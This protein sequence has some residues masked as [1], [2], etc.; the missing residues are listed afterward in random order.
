MPRSSKT[1]AKGPDVPARPQRAA[2][3]AGVAAATAPAKDTP[4]EAKANRLDKQKKKELKSAVVPAKSL[5]ELKRRASSSASSSPA[6]KTAHTSAHAAAALPKASRGISADDSSNESSESEATPEEYELGDLD[7]SADEEGSELEELDTHKP[8]ALPTTKQSRVKKDVKLVAE[9][10]C[11]GSRPAP[12]PTL[13][14]PPPKRV[15]ATERMTGSEIRLRDSLLPWM[16]R[17]MVS[18]P[19]SER[20]D[21]TDFI[22]TFW[23]S[24]LHIAKMVDILRLKSQDI[25]E[26]DITD[27]VLDQARRLSLSPSSLLLTLSSSYCSSPARELELGTINSEGKIIAWTN[28]AA[29]IAKSLLDKF[30]Q[31]SLLWDPPRA[32]GDPAHPSHFLRN[33]LTLRI[34]CAIIAETESTTFGA[35]PVP[36]PR[37]STDSD[38]GWA[39]ERDFFLGTL[40]LT[41]CAERHLL[42]T[43]A[44]PKPT[45]DFSAANFHDTA[46]A[47]HLKLV[48][49]QSEGQTDE[50]HM[51]LV[52][53][54]RELYSIRRRGRGRGITSSSSA[55]HSE[56]E[57]ST[58]LADDDSDPFDF[59]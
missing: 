36:A 25:S 12:P 48:R 11:L 2:A 1:R 24:R 21:L 10:T 50:Y 56:I 53:E 31:C 13:A 14:P 17:V 22:G 37:Q 43:I 40:M 42:A 8:K 4:A 26:G 57:L 41:I 45:L 30:M 20:D 27:A 28:D 38:E 5:T 29:Q 47:V 6:I 55:A 18:T 44:N 59:A 23:P 52:D 46:E 54:L 3:A 35:L 16:I 7:N 34:A 33:P 51:A 32:K 19:P 58:A 15:R 9:V 39:E 49:L